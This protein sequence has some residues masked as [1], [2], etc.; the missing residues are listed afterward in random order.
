MV[1]DAVREAVWCHRDLAYAAARPQRDALAERDRPVRDVGAPLGALRTAEQAG[2]G[3]DAGRTSLVL[4]GRDRAVGR[5][6][7]P[8][9]LVEPARHR[10]PEQPECNRWQRQL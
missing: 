4:A 1:Q 3:V 10:L 7:V 9:E 8:S 5:P 6:P 2:A